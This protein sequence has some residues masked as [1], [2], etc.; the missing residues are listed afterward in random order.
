VSTT[1]LMDLAEELGT[2]AATRFVH[3]FADLWPAR[4]ARIHAAIRAQDSAAAMD[5]IL[6][7][8]SG[9]LMA[10]A[11]PL[12]GHADLIRT[13]LLG[14]GCPAW[15]HACHLLAALDDLGERTVKMLR[16]SIASWPQCPGNN[17]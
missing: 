16:S 6:S 7:L 1:V 12:A 2:D 11:G 13:T 3:A 17:H 8:R 15:E 14:P 10:G 4:R 5:A 9:A